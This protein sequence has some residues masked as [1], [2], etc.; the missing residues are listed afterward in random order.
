[1]GRSTCPRPG[2]SS[3][4]ASGGDP[5]A[6]SPVGTCGALASAPAAPSPERLAPRLRASLARPAA[7]PE[8]RSPL[9]ELLGPGGLKAHQCFVLHG[10]ANL[11]RIAAHLAVLEIGLLRHRRVQ[12]HRNLF[13]AVRTREI[14]FHRP[15]RIPQIAAR[16]HPALWPGDATLA[17]GSC[18]PTH[19]TGIQRYMWFR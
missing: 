5:T 4:L 14:V 19:G 3:R 17:N 6:P 7:A 12:N 18:S 10:V 15:R 11:D 13:A 2:N 9:A 8:S 1:M 16:T